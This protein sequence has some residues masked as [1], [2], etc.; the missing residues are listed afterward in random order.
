MELLPV[1]MKSGLGLLQLLALLLSRHCL[2]LVSL[3]M[4]GMR[5]TDTAL[6]VDQLEK[7]PWEFSHGEILSNLKYQFFLTPRRVYWLLQ[8]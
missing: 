5:A 2:V 7:T 3:V 4:M 8:L 6:L 1:Y